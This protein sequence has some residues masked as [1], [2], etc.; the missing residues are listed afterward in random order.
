MCRPLMPAYWEIGHYFSQSIFLDSYSPEIFLNYSYKLLNWLEA[1]EEE[2]N[3]FR[4]FIY[5]A[6]FNHLDP[7]EEGRH[8]FV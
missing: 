6:L 1:G 7:S 8:P 4:P 2:T 3:S 5:V